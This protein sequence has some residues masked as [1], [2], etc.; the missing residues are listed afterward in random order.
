MSRIPWL[1]ARFDS[2]VSCIFLRR[3]RLAVKI[4]VRKA[5][6]ANIDKA[7]KY[8]ATRKGSRFSPVSQALSLSLTL[9]LRRPKQDQFRL[10]QT[11]AIGTVGGAGALLC[12]GRP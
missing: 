9:R 11:A 1:V 3:C 7:L 4:T 2:P 5:W 10:A 6:L 8:E 12:L